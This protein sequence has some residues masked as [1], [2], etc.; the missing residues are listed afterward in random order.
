MPIVS[1]RQMLR[2]AEQNKHAVAAFNVSDV[3]TTEVILEVAYELN[4]PIIIMVWEGVFEIINP[5][6][7][8]FNLRNLLERSPV[9]AALHFDHC[10]SF[11]EIKKAIDLGFSSVM[12][13]ASGLPFDQNVTLT[14]QVVKYAHRYRVDVEAE[15]GVVGSGEDAAEGDMGEGR[16][17]EPQEAKLFVD[18]T[19]VDALAVAVGTA[20]GFYRH[21]PKLDFERL[22]T[23]KEQAQVPLV[24]HGGSGVPEEAVRKAIEL[25]I[26]KVNIATELNVAFLDELKK[27]MSH[28]PRPIFP[29][30]LL[31][32]ARQAMAPVV[33]RKIELMGSVG[34]A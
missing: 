27:I 6:T 25:G 34:Q 30:L 1:F 16:F 5:E 28:E 20:H 23:I 2:N 7:L 32:P 4:S 14:K 3:E 12:I 15:L 17:T 26:N 22:R 24:L 33:R 8:T 13:D 11:E 19:G 29:G 21:D 10:G 9:P 18:Q 31:H